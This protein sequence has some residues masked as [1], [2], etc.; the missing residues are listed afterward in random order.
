MMQMRGHRFLSGLV[1]SLAALCVAAGRSPRSP[2]ATAARTLLASVAVSVLALSATAALAPAAAQA[3]EPWWHVTSGAR[4]SYLPTSGAQDEVEKITVNATGGEFAVK[5]V[6]PGEEEPQLAGSPKFDASAAELQAVLENEHVYGPGNVEV[7]ECSEVTECS[8]L[9]PNTAELHSWIVTFKG[10]LADRAAPVTPTECNAEKQPY[11]SPCVRPYELTGGNSEVTASEI[12]KGK[13]DGEL[14][15]IAENL[16]DGATTSTTTIADQVP[17]GLTPVGVSGT[18]GFSDVTQELACGLSGQVASC[19]APAGLS[20]FFGLIEIRIPV[21][22]NAAAPEKSMRSR[23]REVGRRTPRQTRRSRSRRRG[24]ATPFGV[25]RYEV[26][27]EEEGGGPARQAGEHP[28]QITGSFNLNEGEE[29]LRAEAEGGEAHEVLPAGSLPDTVNS[30]LPPGLI[31]NATAIPR[32]TISQFLSRPVG[33]EGTEDDCPAASAVGVVTLEVDETN[34]LGL[35][36]VRLPLFNLEPAKGEPARFGFYDLEGETPVILDTSVRSG[37]D[38]GVTLGSTNISQTI[39]LMSFS[40]TFWGV[41]GDPRH[42]QQ[43]GWKCLAGEECPATDEQHPPA[44]LSLPTSCT[45]AM[46][47]SLVWELVGRSRPAPRGRPARAVS[48][49]DIQRDPG[50]G[51]L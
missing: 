10:A 26:T 19:A 38:Y 51:R 9:T 37:G 32:C 2:R 15:V 14:V 18:S 47:T 25:E 24:Q 28:F 7:K 1:P 45:G 22:W 8:E 21:V 12:T 41:P 30:L 31:G 6:V 33:R 34:G 50:H 42:D 49:P 23:S 20:A 11:V 48:H 29:T 3:N 46:P 13:A 5:Y 40:L 16:G 4:P 17:A 36:A 44:F 43:R 27:P 35:L 39:G